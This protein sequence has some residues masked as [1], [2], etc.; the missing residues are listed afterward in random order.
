MTVFIWLIIS[1]CQ[2]HV[3]HQVRYHS[4]NGSFSVQANDSCWLIFLRF[5]L[6]LIIPLWQTFNYLAE[7]KVS[8]LSMRCAGRASDCC[9]HILFQIH[10]R[11]FFNLYEALVFDRL[12]LG[13]LS[14]TLGVSEI[15]VCSFVYDIARLLARVGRVYLT[16]ACKVL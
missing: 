16:W 6:T 3:Q 10:V 8:Y 5:L 13:L 2:H 14:P 9:R 11:L 12:I 4:D 15:S 1:F 7:L